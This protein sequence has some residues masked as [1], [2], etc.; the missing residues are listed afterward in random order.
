MSKDEIRGQKQET[1]PTNFTGY[2]QLDIGGRTGG[3]Y[4]IDQVSGVMDE[5]DEATANRKLPKR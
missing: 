3:T 1:N 5:G 2:R 4:R